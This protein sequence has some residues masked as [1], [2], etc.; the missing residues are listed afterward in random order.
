MKYEKPEVRE[1]SCAVDAIRSQANKGA[2][3]QDAPGESG[4]QTASAYE[5]DE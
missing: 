2:P 3:L 4:L 1:L 5:A